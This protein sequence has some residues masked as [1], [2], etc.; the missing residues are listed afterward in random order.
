MVRSIPEKTFEHWSSMYVAHR[1]PRGG[2]WWPT[3]GEDIHVEDLG[4]LPGK[5]VLLETKVPELATTG[6]H[7]VSVDLAQLKRYVSSLVPVY[8]VFPEPPWVGDLM[9]SG[10]LGGERRADLAYRRAGD[11]WF[12]EWTL[13]CG[14]ADLL[15]HLAPTPVQK[16]ATVTTPPPQHW[17]WFDFWSD[18]VRCGS[19]TMPAAFIVPTDD[20]AAELE[21]GNGTISRTLLRAELLELR[22]ALAAQGRSEK[23]S[24]KR[25]ER[26]RFVEELRSMRKSVLVPVGPVDGDD[27]YREVSDEEL[28]ASMYDILQADDRVGASEEDIDS[29]LSVSAVPFDSLAT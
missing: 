4:T 1:F 18:L 22:G 21:A 16:T 24:Q 23:R 19:R 6:A 28:A 29:H 12:G 14:A 2:L 5:S 11:R 26:D 10:W 8:Y 15:A 3:K 17:R 7:T 9:V 20:V 13:V 25:A 27:L